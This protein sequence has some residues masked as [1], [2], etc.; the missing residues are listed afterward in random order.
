MKADPAGGEDDEDR[1]ED[2]GHDVEG[3]HRVLLGLEEAVPLDVG[4]DIGD[5]LGVV[6]GKKL[7]RGH[8][9]VAGAGDAEGNAPADHLS[10]PHRLDAPEVLPELGPLHDVRLEVPV[11]LQGQGRVDVGEQLLLVQEDPDFV[12][13]VFRELGPD[14][15]AQ[16]RPVLGADEPAGDDGPAQL[17]GVMVGQIL[18]VAGE[19]VGHAL[20]VVQEP[21]ERGLEPLLDVPADEV[22]G[23]K[24]QEE[25]RNEGQGDEKRDQL[26]LEVG[27]DDLPLA[28]EAEL[29]QVPPEDEEAG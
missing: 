29:D 15:V 23:E 8:Q 2:E 17:L 20:R 18:G 22:A 27:A 13:L 16:G 4:G 10:A 24:E 28:F 11:V 1:D 5:L 25:G 9:A 7:A 26:R 19:A 3:L 14:E 12:E 6:L 21:V